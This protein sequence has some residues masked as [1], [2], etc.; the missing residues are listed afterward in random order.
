MT[1]PLAGARI[2]AA[3][4]L[5]IF[6]GN[7]DAFTTYV[8]TLTQSATPTKNVEYAGWF[9]VGRWVTVS[10]SLAVTSAGTAAN[11]VVIGLPS[12][13]GTPAS[14]RNI[15]G[16]SIYDASANFWYTG[17]AIWQSASTFVIIPNAAATG[18][19]ASSFTAALASGDV[20]TATLS[21]QVTS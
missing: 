7:T 6:P 13:A 1:L 21:Y 9:K 8:P 11:A 2:K 15:G 5:A 3:D 4:L 17:A 19:G 12:A 16:G 10:L 20:V 18:L 14:Y